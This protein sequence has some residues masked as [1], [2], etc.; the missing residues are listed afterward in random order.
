[1]TSFPSRVITAL[2]PCG[3][4]TLSKPFH[5]C[6]HL[7]LTMG[8]DVWVPE[9]H[10][11][12]CK[13]LTC[14]MT[15]TRDGSGKGSRLRGGWRRLRFFLSKKKKNQDLGNT[16]GHCMSETHQGWASRLV[17]KTGAPPDGATE[18]RDQQTKL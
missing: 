12:L 15:H 9:P 8:K 11:I 14:L 1:M 3:V 18:V 2:P 17:L 13:T 10:Y 6:S 4:S 16:C 7:N 5:R